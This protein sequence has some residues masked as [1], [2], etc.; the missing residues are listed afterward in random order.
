LIDLAL[1]TAFKKSENSDVQQD[2]REGE[3]EG[4]QVLLI[5]ELQ[6]LLHVDLNL[7]ANSAILI[8][9]LSELQALLRVDLNPYRHIRLRAAKKRR[10]IGFSGREETC[11]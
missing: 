11:G 6:A 5:E 7:P 9:L 3:Q 2:Q 10:G 1:A 4:L 8:S